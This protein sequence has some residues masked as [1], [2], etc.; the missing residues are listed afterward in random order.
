MKILIPLPQCDFDPTEVAVSWQILA[1]AGHEVIFATPEG[2]VAQADPVMLDGIGLDY[3]SRIPALKHLTL[4]GLALR[5]DRRGRT[6]HCALVHNAAFL[7]Q[8]QRAVS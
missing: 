6:A 8:I 5:A 3:W 1:S 7:A 4:V 2:A